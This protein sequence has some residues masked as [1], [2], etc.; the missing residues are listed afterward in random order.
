[1]YL[2]SFVL[3]L[4]MVLT[5]IASAADPSLVGWLKF[6]E[7]S[8]NTAYNPDPPD[9]AQFIA[10]YLTLNWAAGFS[11]AS[12]D[13]YFSTDEQAVIDGTAPVATVTESSYGPLSLD[14]GTTYYWRVDEVDGSTTHKGDV[15]SFTT[16]AQIWAFPDAEGWAAST[17]G[18]RG[19]KIIRVTNL[20]TSG[21][22]SFAAAVAASGPRIVVFEVG[23]V[24]DLKGTHI[25]IR[26]PYLTIAGQ[27]APSPGITFIDGSIK[28]SNTH[29]IV[30]QHICVRPGASRHSTG[31][32]P[33]GIAL[34]SAYNVIL[35]HCSVSWAVDENMSASGPRFEGS[36]PDDWRSNTSHAVTFSNNI[37]AEGL[38]YATHQKG[39]H[40]KGSLIHDN[41][42]EIAIVK[43][44]YAS[45]VQRNPYFKGGAR[46]VVVNNYIYNPG[47]KAMHYNL[48]SSEW[49]GYSYQTGK[50]TVIGNVLQYGPN[51]RNLS[52]LDVG[53]GPA[54]IYLE[55]N[56][57]KDQ[58][59]KSVDVY[60]GSISK[61]VNIKP[62]WIDNLQPI[63][64]SDVRDYIV[65]NA[66]ARPWDRDAIDTRIINEML[67]GTGQIIDFETEVGG[68]PDHQPTY[69]PF[70]EEEWDLRT[71]IQISPRVVELF[72]YAIENITATASSAHQADM[73]PEN[74]ING[75]G[76]DADD[77]HST[78]E[79]Y[80][81]LSGSE[82]LG[83]WIEFQF[84]KV[85]KLHEMWVWNSNQMM[86]PILGLGCKDVSV[87]YSVN[88]IDYTSLGATHEFARAPGTSDYA[89]NTTVELSG[90]AAK[91]VRL[92]A[93][94]N[95]GGILN[96]YG[97]SEVRFFRIPRARKPYPDS[98][99]TDVDL[100]VVLSW[101]AGR[102]AAEHDVHL[103]TDEQAVIDGTAYVG[104]VSEASY[105]AGGLELGTTYYWRVDEVNEAETPTTWQGDIWSFTTM[106]DPLAKTLD[107]RLRFTTGGSAD[108]F[109]QTTTF[110]N[111][112]DAAQSGDI[113]GGQESWM[114]TTVSGAGTVKFYWKVSSEEDFDFLKFYIDGSSQDRISG[115]VDWHQMTYTI[116]TSGSHVLEWRYVKDRSR[117]R[118]SDC[119]DCGWVDKV[120]WVTTP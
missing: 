48:P 42:S 117:G 71:M 96:Q 61:L 49:Q 60:D 75:S 100:D 89:H 17:P 21:S 118:G 64:A 113:S 90:V 110:Y 34:N 50:M 14:L 10:P 33:D 105:D 54:E 8:G 63:P 83:A 5:S 70:N 7:G 109:S 55:D 92:T 30:I 39:E 65:Q 107:T 68:Y 47:R 2:V 101:R 31:W 37:I 76:L 19:G 103:S 44:L 57:A 27:T 3:V 18:G 58:S 85:C 15:W 69:A 88:G 95:W 84:D 20:N 108:W 77:L 104:T 35:D 73:G 81:W 24:I 11:A 87:E 12:Y 78:V 67:R 112:G 86:E 45:N 26:D 28:I 6:D 56:M 119:S 74:T 80:M 32:E 52:L 97:L 114:Q 41:T 16:H 46:G 23:G 93:N 111:D 43:N 120:E 36:S 66:G 82:P 29:D 99:A 51:T 102:E 53:N 38:S 25:R 59:G 79:T 13:V 91:Y 94:N 40:S 62:V 98:R 115:S 106:A 1:M 4:V 22:G 72:A 9:G 116:S